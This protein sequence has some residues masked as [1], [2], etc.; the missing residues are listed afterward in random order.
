MYQWD[1][2]EHCDVPDTAGLYQQHLV[3]INEELNVLNGSVACLCF[4]S[5]NDPECVRNISTAPPH[6]WASREPSVGLYTAHLVS[7]EVGWKNGAAL[8][9]LGQLMT[10]S[11]QGRTGSCWVYMASNQGFPTV[12]NNMRETEAMSV[13]FKKV[14]RNKKIRLKSIF[15]QQVERGKALVCVLATFRL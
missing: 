7:S 2:A 1:P 11:V 15:Q 6:I 13:L 5:N 8:V 14:F 10:G 9:W 4:L 3:L 12:N